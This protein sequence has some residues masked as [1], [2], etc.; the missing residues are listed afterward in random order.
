MRGI[1]GRD[2]AAVVF[3][4]FDICGQI[5]RIAQRNKVRMRDFLYKRKFLLI[6]IV[7]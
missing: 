4:E 3:S 2:G 1:S 6:S 7:I 5:H